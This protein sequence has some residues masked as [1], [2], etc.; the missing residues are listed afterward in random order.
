LYQLEVRH[1]LLVVET[2][3]EKAVGGVVVGAAAAMQENWYDA[4]LLSY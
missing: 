4:D 2:H 3:V 1:G